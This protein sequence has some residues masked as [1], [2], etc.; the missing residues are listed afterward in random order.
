MISDEALLKAHNAMK[1]DRIQGFCYGETYVVRDV[2][3][4]YEKQQLWSGTDEQE[5]QD[6]CNIERVRLAYNV[7]N[8][9]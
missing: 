5:F 3:L 7:M 2:W 8:S 6:R 4:P 1:P 9:N